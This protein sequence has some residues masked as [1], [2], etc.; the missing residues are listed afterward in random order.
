M[1]RSQSLLLL[2]LGLPLGC[3]GK[4]NA[5][6]ETSDAAADS[7]SYDAGSDSSHVVDSA[8]DDSP[9][10]FDASTDASPPPTEATCAKLQDAMCGSATKACCTKESFAYDEMGCRDA[11]DTWCHYQMDAVTAGYATYDDSQLGPCTKVWQTSLTACTVTFQPWTKDYAVCTALFNGTKEP[12]SDCNP[13]GLDSL[14]CKA[15]PGFSGYCDQ[16]DKKCR[17]YGIV[18]NGEAC[19]FYGSVLRYCDVGLYCDTTSSPTSSVCKPAKKL[20]DACS[21]ADDLSC[22]WGNSCKDGKCTAGLPGG[23]DCTNAIDCA[24]WQ[25]TMGKCTPEAFP[26][27][28][29]GMCN[30]T[31]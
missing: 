24:S 30:G 27:V 8:I 13:K 22:G 5:P 11:I 14:G 1:T 31:G 7:G 17:A 21:G 6:A 12:G 2:M 26:V 4:V 25:C 19:T 18:G 28:T 23:A 3:G 16:T 20:G 9:V 29:A 10:E 15:P